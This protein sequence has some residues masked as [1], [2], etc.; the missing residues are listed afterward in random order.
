MIPIKFDAIKR[1]VGNS[2]MV[3]IPRGLGAML[4]EDVEYT[5]TITKKEEK[6]EVE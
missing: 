3:T 4:D 6:Q 5:F 1:K 2:W